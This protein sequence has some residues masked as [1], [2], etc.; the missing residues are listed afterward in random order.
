MDTSS[1]FENL[2][3]FPPSEPFPPVHR[4]KEKE[5]TTQTMSAWVKE[6]WMPQNLKEAMGPHYCGGG[7]DSVH[8][9]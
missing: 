7:S 3:N 2:T 4:K 5:N 1:V 6:V 9:I 8:R